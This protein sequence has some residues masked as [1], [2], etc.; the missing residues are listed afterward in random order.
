MLCDVWCGVSGVLW[1][2]PI[3]S[4]IYLFVQTALVCANEGCTWN[5]HSISIY[6]FMHHSFFLGCTWNTHSLRTNIGLYIIPSSF[7]SVTVRTKRGSSRHVGR[8]LRME[9]HPSSV[10]NPRET[11]STL[12]K[13]IS[14]YIQFIVSPTGDYQYVYY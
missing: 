1:M 5:T 10:S 13:P 9:G 2:V 6:R 7:H 14:I 3:H 12:Y 4:F 8:R 11:T